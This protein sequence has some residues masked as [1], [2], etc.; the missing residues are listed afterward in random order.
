VEPIAV[1]RRDVES[2]VETARQVA[3][4]RGKSVLAWWLGPERRD[5]EDGLAARGLVHADTPGYE[6]VESGMALLHSP[7]VSVSE[8]IAVKEVDSYED[9]VAATQILLEAFDF[10][11]AIR[12]DVIDGLPMRWKEYTT[13]SNPGRQFIASIDGRIVGTAF[14]VFGAVG[15]NLFGGGV[16]PEARGLGV[17]RALVAAR[18]G[19]A[20]A[21]GTPVLTVQAGRMSKPIVERLGFVEVGRVH[22]Y[23][24][25]IGD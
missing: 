10:P 23:V 7:P 12:A 1:A 18:W 11:D 17:Y 20:V 4:E 25:T 15:V 9:Y 6:A 13:P 8:G 3:R 22:V 5:L 19:A 16:L 21:R 14:A 2:A 24:D